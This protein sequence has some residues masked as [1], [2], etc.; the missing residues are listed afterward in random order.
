MH[1]CNLAEKIIPRLTIN[2]LSRIDPTRTLGIRNRFVREINKRFGRLKREIKQSILDNDCFGI[3]KEPVVLEAVKERQFDF[4]RTQ[5]KVDAFMRW[6]EVQEKEY[7]LS[8]GKRGL[9]LIRRPGTR[10]GEEEA[11]TDLYVHSAYQQGIVRARQ[12]MRKAGY[13]IPAD[14]A[15]F[16]GL[17]AAFNQPFHIDRLGVLYTRTF[18]DLKTVT[19]FTNAQVRRKIADG[20]TTGLTKGIAEGKNPRTIAR[21][22]V[23]DVANRVDAIGIT[24]ARLIARTEVIRAHHQASIAE[25]K[26]YE[27]E[28][29]SIVAEWQTA[30]YEVCEECEALEGKTFSLDEIE[31]M[32]P[33][34]P[35]CRCV[36]IPILKE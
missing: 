32:I 6:L 35:Q 18:E 30:G 3:Q 13:N 28:G 10:L 15:L 2:R 5:S 16:G 7:V 17:N 25:F 36:A 11:W 20:L 9:Q 26:E 1:K 8:G 24:R 23:K 14:D 31:G 19:Q 33:L 22:L 21:E 12:E 34:H 27:V 29:V 4:V